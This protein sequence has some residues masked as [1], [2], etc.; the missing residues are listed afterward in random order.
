MPRAKITVLQ[1]TVNQE[2]ADAYMGEE[3]RN[4]EGG[5]ICSQFE[6]GQEFIL[7]SWG[8]VPKGFCAWAWADIHKY[9]LMIMGGGF[10]DTPW[11]IPQN[12]AIACCTDGYRPV[13]FKIEALDD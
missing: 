11:V 13:I 3:Y 12:A 7:D 2:I 4:R 5:V 9:I 8:T 6:D 1:R 10:Y